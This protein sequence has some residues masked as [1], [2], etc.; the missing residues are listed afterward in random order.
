MDTARA[1]RV[2]DRHRGVGADGVVIS[3]PVGV[4]EDGRDDIWVSGPRDGQK[5][6]VQGQDF[7]KEGQKVEPVDAAA[8]PAAPQISRS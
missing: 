6:I 8:P 5:I 7:V 2:C 4:V 1:R 3:I